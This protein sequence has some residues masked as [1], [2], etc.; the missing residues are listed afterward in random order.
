MGAMDY[1]DLAQDMDRWRHLQ[2][3]QWAFGFY[4]MWGISWPAANRLA[5][6][7]GLCSM[8]LVIFALLE[9]MT[10]LWLRI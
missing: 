3:R 9:V 8:E 4:K 2:T 1:I 10:A 5:F 6:Q 7:E